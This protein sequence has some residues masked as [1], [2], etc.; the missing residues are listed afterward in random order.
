M[1]KRPIHNL[2]NSFLIRYAFNKVYS[3]NTVSVAKKTECGIA[4]YLLTGGF[5][6]D[7]P[8]LATPK[9]QKSIILAAFKKNVGFLTRSVGAD[10]GL[11]R[12]QGQHLSITCDIQ[13]AQVTYNCSDS[14][15]D[16]SHMINHIGALTRLSEPSKTDESNL[17]KAGILKNRITVTP[18]KKRQRDLGGKVIRLPHMRNKLSKVK[19]SVQ[20]QPNIFKAGGFLGSE[21]MRADWVLE[22]LIRE[23][24]QSEKKSPR[25]II[26]QYINNVRMLMMSMGSLC[27]VKGL[28]IVITGRLGSRKKAMAQQISKCIGKVPLNTLRQNIDY[29]Q[30]FL[31]TRF[32]VMGIK[33]WVCYGL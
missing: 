10:A 33:V 25:P 21:Y 32:G 17:V 8:G 19:T 28:R 15:N 7:L 13:T 16:S 14:R 20:I 31:T 1:N 30:D 24:G 27:P 5:G 22:K 26:N 3:S 2:E 12:E 18:V 29:S 11:Y 6:F 23:F 4:Q 9:L